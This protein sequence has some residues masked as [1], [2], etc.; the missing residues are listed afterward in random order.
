MNSKCLFVKHGMQKSFASQNAFSQ[1]FQMSTAPS[2][3]SF[4]PEP[5]Y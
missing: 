1:Y 4:T 5:G 2:A 3:A